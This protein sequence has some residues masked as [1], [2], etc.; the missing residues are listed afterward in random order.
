MD[1]TNISFLF[2][3]LYY[4]YI[5]CYHWE[6]LGGG[7]NRYLYI[8]SKFHTNFK[9]RDHENFMMVKDKGEKKVVLGRQVRQ[10]L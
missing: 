4:S 2:V 8:I 7:N 9:K 10:L 1:C 3:I 6:K 5:R